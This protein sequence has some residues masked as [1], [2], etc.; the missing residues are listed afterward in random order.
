MINIILI[1]GLSQILIG[2]ILGIIFVVLPRRRNNLATAASIFI[3]IGIFQIVFGTFLQV[4]G[5]YGN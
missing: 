1:G 4:V 5:L 3:V 2:V